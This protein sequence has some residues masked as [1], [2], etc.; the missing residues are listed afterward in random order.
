MSV[1]SN[2][3]QYFLKIVLDI[4]VRVPCFAYFKC[5]ERPDKY[6]IMIFNDH[7]LHS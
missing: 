1:A 3:M 5:W 7:V 6:R 2:W 4:Q